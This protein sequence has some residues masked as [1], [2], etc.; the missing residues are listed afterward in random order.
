MRWSDV[1]DGVISITQDKTGKT[2]W[3]PVHSELKSEL[4]NIP[5]KSIFI[6][7][8]SK[9]QPWATGFKASW[10]KELA[11]PAMAPIKQQGL[12]FHGLRKSA[13]VFLLEAGCTDAEVSA[14][15]GQTRQM[16]EHYSRQVNQQHLAR[17]AILK[18]EKDG[19]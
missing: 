2:V 16:V 10:R 9:E 12:V 8:N 4:E 13:V 11:K 1:K 18:W 5:R 6:L 19:K 3:V 14:I 7:T 17:E 15:T